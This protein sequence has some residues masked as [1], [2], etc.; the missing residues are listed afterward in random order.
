MTFDKLQIDLTSD[1]L[2]AEL[3]IPRH[4]SH[5]DQWKDK[6]TISQQ[7]LGADDQDQST[8]QMRNELDRDHTRFHRN[9]TTPT[10]LPLQC[11]LQIFPDD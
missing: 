5:M 3:L 6:D 1:L 9:K 11:F 7:S 2:C 8:D 10:T 4:R